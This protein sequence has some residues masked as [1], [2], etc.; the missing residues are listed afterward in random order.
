M[1]LPSLAIFRDVVAKE[2]SSDGYLYWRC[3]DITL[4]YKLFV[5]NARVLTSNYIR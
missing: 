3:A 1:F 5:I 4:K 2:K